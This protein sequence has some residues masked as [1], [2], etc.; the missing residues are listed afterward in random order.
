MENRFR[1]RSDEEG[2]RLDTFLAG[3]LSVTRTKIKEMFEGGHVRIAGRIPKPS[4]TTK[5][6]MEIEGE[7]PEEKPLVLTPQDIPLD[8]LYEDD[9]FLA[10]NK[11]KG[12]VVHPSFGHKEGTLVNAILSY[13]GGAGHGPWSTEASETPTDEVCVSCPPFSCFATQDHIFTAR[14]GIVHRL[15]KGTTGVILV[16]KDLKTQELLSDLFKERAVEKTY[17]TITEGLPERDDGVVEGNIGRHPT[18]RKKMAVLTRGGRSAVTRFKVMQRLQDYAYIEVYP[19]T[20]RTHQ[21]RVHLAHIGHPVVGDETY[22]KRAKH[23]CD[24]PLLHA[25]R[26]AFVHP[27]S[28]S[29]IAIEAPMPDDMERFIASHAA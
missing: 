18:N 7:I 2:K 12:M 19:R 26:I 11:P 27:I 14:P 24:R 4:L 13:L 5:M 10:V 17:R 28:G 6:G 20:G 16:A 9:F 29:Q 8:I 15:D 3:K 25:Y 21:I 23:L 1:I 22:G